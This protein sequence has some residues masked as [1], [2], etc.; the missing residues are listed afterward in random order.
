MVRNLR[1]VKPY[2]TLCTKENCFWGSK[3]LIVFLEDDQKPFIMK[4]S[5]DKPKNCKV[6]KV[7]YPQYGN[8]LKNSEQKFWSEKICRGRFFYLLEKG[9]KWNLFTKQGCIQ[10][11]DKDFCVTYYLW[12]KVKRD[13]RWRMCLLSQNPHLWKKIY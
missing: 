6:H 2:F 5:F 10:N 8:R 1:I 12:K 9:L 3:R 4:E 7:I 11:P 13:I